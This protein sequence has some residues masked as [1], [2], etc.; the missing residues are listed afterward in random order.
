MAM[1][2]IRSLL[3][4]KFFLQY[5]LNFNSQIM[6]KSFILFLILISAK[7]FSAKG[8]NCVFIENKGQWPKE[9]LFLLQSNGVDTWIT[10]QGMTYD[11]YSLKEEGEK[12]IKSG[13][14]ITFKNANTLPDNQI[15]VLAKQKQQAY[16]N[17]FM[18][19]NPEHWTSNVGLYKE[20]LVK[21]IYSG[22]DMRY[23]FEGG[24]L[25]Y[26]Y[27]VHPNADVHQIK[28]VLEGANAYQLNEKG[29][30]IFATRYGE[31]KQ[32][33]LY[34]YQIV[35][36]SKKT[37]HSSFSLSGNTL[38]F[39]TDN[40]DK[41]KPLIIDPLVWSTYIGAAASERAQSVVEMNGNAYI[42]GWT[43]QFTGTAFP[44][45]TGVYDNVWS[46]TKAFVSKFSNDGSS[47]IYSTYLGSVSNS[48]GGNVLADGVFLAVDSIGNAYITG[49]ADFGY[50]TTP[51]AYNTT[52]N[53]GVFVTKLNNTGTALIYST[54][55]GGGNPRAI[56]IDGLGYA[57][58]TGGASSGFP[59]TAGAYAQTNNGSHDV[60]ITKLDTN[61]SSLKFSTYLGGSGDYEEGFGIKLD[62]NYNV[63]VAGRASSSNF[64]TTAGAYDQTY[65]GGSGTFPFDGFVAKLNNIGSNLIFSTFIGGSND[66]EIYGLDIDSNNDIYVTGYTLSTNFPYTSGVH[67][68]IKDGTS[69]TSSS[70]RDAFVV[71][72]NNSGS[73][74][75]YSTFF[76][77][78]GGQEA[79][80]ITVDQNNNAWI[81]GKTSS[82]SGSI[83][84]T[85]DA[86]DKIGDEG[87]FAGLNSTATTLLYCS[88]VGGT[89]SGAENVPKALTNDYLGGIYM[90]GWTG[91]TDFTVTTGAFQTTNNSIVAQYSDAFVLK[92]QY[93]SSTSVTQNTTLNELIVYPNPATDIVNLKGLALGSVINILDI[94]G[95]R[96][97]STIANNDVHVLNTTGF[98]EGVYFIQIIGNEN[99][100]LNK[101]L[102]ISRK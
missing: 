26:D 100:L 31:M 66:D 9:V 33:D 57:Y 5:I 55:I 73:A 59:T 75:I 51:G 88:H 17:F 41:S 54:F 48:G 90:A 27:I 49:K 72:L 82:S 85:N 19:N 87:F 46:G 14:V 53:S 64:P 91:A 98:A 47:L 60:F 101:K 21:N 52:A 10:K 84:V 24:N 37:V 70:S 86:F 8:D 34:T 38:Q 32:A 30:L 78:A 6:K 74:L 102:V 95:K 16:Y 4:S 28:I 79:L 1:Y 44:T 92:F 42:S 65:N 67:D 2:T 23:Y 50:P 83:P 68:T 7:L 81:C 69:S 61:A 89:T 77:A 93:G 18:D 29:E 76:G 25:R 43:T 71:K 94:T 36:G 12:T 58:I 35:N 15:S 3:N 63:I 99:Q 62:N 20:A 45:T 22:I 40:Y 96:I 97:Y 13:H 80:A 56:T 39:N 11:V